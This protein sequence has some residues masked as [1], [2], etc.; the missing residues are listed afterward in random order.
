MAVGSLGL[1]GQQRRNEPE[2]LQLEVAPDE[3]VVV[4]EI[5]KQDRLTIGFKDLC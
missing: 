2:T 3:T 1:V 5:I 4:P